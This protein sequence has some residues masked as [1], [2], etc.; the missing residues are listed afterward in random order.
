MGCIYKLVSL[1]KGNILLPKKFSDDEK[2]E[3][4][5]NYLQSFK[6]EGSTTKW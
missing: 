1:G 2:Y 3:K 5:I 4:A 6:E